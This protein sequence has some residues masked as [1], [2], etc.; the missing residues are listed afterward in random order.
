VEI[1]FDYTSEP[2]TWVLA[3]NFRLELGYKIS[4]KN[5]SRVPRQ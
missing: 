4:V 5:A 2:L 3:A 1:L